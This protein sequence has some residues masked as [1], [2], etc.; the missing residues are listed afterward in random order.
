VIEVGVGSEPAR[1]VQL[2]DGEVDADDV[3]RRADEP[4]ADEGIHP[5]AAAQVDHPLTRP[6]AREVEEVADT[7]ERID[8]PVGNR[9]EQLTGVAEASGE[10]ASHL[11]VEGGFRL[12]G[13]LPIY[14]LNLDPQLLGVQHRHGCSLRKKSKDRERSGD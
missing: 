11:E 12:L 6:Q 5:R 13:H 4:R 8:G 9:V 2:L 10:F 3:S 7:R 14:L 1:L